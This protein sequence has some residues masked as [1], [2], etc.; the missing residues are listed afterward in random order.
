MSALQH[1]PLVALVVVAGFIGLFLV[2]RR[3]RNFGWVDVAWAGGFAPIA[4]CYALSGRGAPLP[5]ALIALM[6]AGWSLRLAIML[7]LRVWS[8]H[9]VED[10]RYAQLRREWGAALDVK[11]A[12]F[13]VLQA[14]LQVLLSAPVALAVER[15][16]PG[17]GWTDWIALALWALALSG[18]TLAD[19]QLAGFKRDPANKGRV[20][21]RGL[22][23]W[24]RHPNYFFEWLVWVA[25]AL[26]ITP[27]PWGW[28][29][30]GCPVLMGWFLVFVTG[31]RYTE[32]QLLRSK[33]DAYRAYQQRTSAFLPLPPRP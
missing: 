16:R 9:P 17:L 1:L 11:M 15:S 25:F 8:H 26:A 14:L 32:E 13:Y 21:T 30:W 10:G 23:R 24:S 19:W 6:V 28:L 22:W 20:C 5:R 31:V 33:G 2:A 4:V 18:E 29:A 12:G 7:G 27:A 3:L